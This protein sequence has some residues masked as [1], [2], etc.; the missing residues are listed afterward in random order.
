MR[1]GVP[2]KPHYQLS[3][4]ARIISVSY[5]TAKRMAD[6]QAIQRV[7]LRPNGR[8]LVPQ[9]EVERVLRRLGTRS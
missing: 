8:R 7:R 2:A 9:R 5:S 6:E 3:E 1:N 4:V